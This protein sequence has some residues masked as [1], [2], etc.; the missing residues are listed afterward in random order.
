MAQYREIEQ[1]L[2]SKCANT[3]PP[4]QEQSEAERF[5][6]CLAAY[7]PKPHLLTG[8]SVDLGSAIALVNKYCARL[9]SDTFT[10]LTALWRCTRNERAG[11]TLFQYT[12]RLPINSPLKHDIVVSTC[13]TNYLRFVKY[14]SL[15][16]SDAN[17]NIGPPTGC[18]TGLR[19]TAQDR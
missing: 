19:G 15:G 7:R 13:N 10:K 17:S 11:V 18:L 6:A 12:L 5:S 16:S 1:M 3:E 4:E 9:P 2:L 8:A 14:S